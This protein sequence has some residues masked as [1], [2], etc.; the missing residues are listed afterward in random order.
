MACGVCFP[1]TTVQQPT[2]T[3]N[4][5]LVTSPSKCSGGAPSIERGV[6]GSLCVSGRVAKP[7]GQASRMRRWPTSFR[8]CEAGLHSRSP[9]QQRH[10]SWSQG[11]TV[12]CQDSGDKGM[13]SSVNSILNSRATSSARRG[14]CMQ[15]KLVS[16]PCCGAMRALLPGAVLTARCMQPSHAQWWQHRM[17]LELTLG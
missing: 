8:A 10:A 14:R 9:A 5:L 4:M 15:R 3:P 6:V 12:H 16:G 2:G 17:Q 11:L 7:Q 1:A 13:F